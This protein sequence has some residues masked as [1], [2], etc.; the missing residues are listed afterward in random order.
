MFY[1]GNVSHFIHK[2]ILP[3]NGVSGVRNL[4]LLLLSTAVY[5]NRALAV[6]NGDGTTIYTSNTWFHEIKLWGRE[7]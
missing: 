2:L 5:I 4:S 7:Q 6:A 3:H 1:K